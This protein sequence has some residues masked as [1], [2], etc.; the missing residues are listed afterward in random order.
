MASSTATFLDT[1]VDVGQ[2]A[3][4]EPIT[5]LP[6]IGLGNALRM[7]VL[8][9]DGRMDAAEALR[10]S[11]VDEVVEPD[12]LLARAVT[13]AEQASSGSPAAIEA[14]KRAIRGALERPISEAMHHFYMAQ[15]YTAS[16]SFNRALKEV[17]KAI[18]L[19]PSNPK[20][21]IGYAAALVQLRRFTEAAALLKRVIASAPNENAAHANLAI[22]LYEMK[23]YAGAIT[24]YEWLAVARPDVPAT[25]FFLATAHDN[26]GEYERA[27]EYYEKFLSQADP[28]NSK[29]DIEKVNLRL[30]SLRAQIKRGQGKKQK[31]P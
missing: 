14:S 16:V 13:L 19:D 4:I 26:L 24:E 6:R 30:P 5:L 23:D 15:S 20:Y 18:E 1:H 25:Y 17:D 8:G 27:L 2:V 22:A 21:A 9:Q 10:I 7:A 12:A 31:R 3:A 11:L 28:A 29:L